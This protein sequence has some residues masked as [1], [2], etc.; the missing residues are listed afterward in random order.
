MIFF[1]E[2]FKTNI[3]MGIRVLEGCLTFLLLSL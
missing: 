1:Q 2:I 3:I